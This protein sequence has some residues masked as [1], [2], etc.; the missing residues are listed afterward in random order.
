VS[1]RLWLIFLVLCVFW[2]IPYFFIKLALEDLSPVCIAWTRITL[3]AIVLVPIAWKRG[4][5]LPVLRHKRAV[6]AFALAELVIPFPLVSLAETWISSS[7][8]GVLIASAPLMLVAMAPWFGI[9]ETFGARRLLGLMIGFVGVIGLMGFDSSGGANQW[10]GVACV[11]IAT[12]GY[13]IGPLIVQRHLKDVH[14]LGSLAVSLII[15]SVL[16]LPF[17]LLSAPAQMPSA[18]SLAS[19]VVLGVICTAAALLLYFYLIGKAGASRASIVAYV[20]PAVAALLGVLVLNEH[21]TSGMV[22]A[23]ALILLGSWMA[24]HSSQVI[25]SHAAKAIAPER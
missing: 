11:M 18:T 17:A 13:V 5:L 2:G 21:F 12:V 25:E 3:A 8:T 16:L 9:R 6:T 20:C 23:F 4:L 10:W 14:Q 15:G 24:T 22:A 7:L 1:W 19:I